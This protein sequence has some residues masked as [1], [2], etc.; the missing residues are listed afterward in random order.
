MK[1]YNL[2]KKDINQLPL[3]D[4]GSK[5]LKLRTASFNRFILAEKK[6]YTELGQPIPDNDALASSFRNLGS[7]EEL[8][9]DII[10]NNFAETFQIP[11]NAGW[12]FP[13]CLAR[14]AQI[15]PPRN[16]QGK[17]SARALVRDHYSKDPFI[18]GIYAIFMYTKRGIFLKNQTSEDSRNYSKLVPLIMSAYKHYGKI[19]YNDWEPSEIHYVVDENLATAMTLEEFDIHYWYALEAGYL[20]E[21]DGEVNLYD[22]KDYGGFPAE[23][24]L[25]WRNDALTVKVGDKRGTIRKPNTTYSLAPSDNNP[26]KPLVLLNRHMFLQTWCAHP[27]NRTNL[28]ILDPLDWDHMPEPLINAHNLYNTPEEDAILRDRAFE[29]VPS[30][31][32]VPW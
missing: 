19:P 27:D 25:A 16:E 17:I 28:M 14:L 6:K 5:Y 3:A 22:G 30:L 32:A 20:P 29:D 21:G 18:M 12:F 8:E 4:L 9:L 11:R 15:K 13:Q 2:V 10:L 31:T 23:T 24:I 7:A 26:V 1:N